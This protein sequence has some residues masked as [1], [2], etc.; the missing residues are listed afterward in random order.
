MRRSPACSPLAARL[1]LLGLTQLAPVALA[2]PKLADMLPSG[3]VLTPAELAAFEAPPPSGVTYTGEPVVAFPVLPLQVFGLHY[4]ADIVLV[5]KDPDWDMHEYARV[6]VPGRT[7][8]LAKDADPNKVQTIVA[9]TPDL[10]ALA[11]E[12]PITRYNRPMTVE[13]RSE[14]ERIDLRLA[15]VNSAGDPV[16][17]SYRGRMAKKPPS[18]RN[19]AT[20]G[21]SAN[22][23]AVV[24][25]LSRF[26]HGG[27]A[28]IEIDGHRWRLDRLLGFYAQKYLLAQTQGGVVIARFQVRPTEGGVHIQRPSP[29][30]EAWPLHSEEDWRASA[31][32]ALTTLCSSNEVSTTCYRFRDG[33]W[34]GAEVRQ[35]GRSTPVF[36]MRLDPALPDVRR[37]FEGAATSRFTFDVDGQQGHGAGVVVARWEAGEARISLIPSAPTDLARRPMEGTVRYAEGAATV[38]THR[39]PQAP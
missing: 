27:R 32:G 33:E 14:G 16:T 26:K 34:L 2:G 10:D 38:E 4:S 8:W 18:K 13:D 36:A 35:A 23:A 12:V 39:V 28:R 3:P 15:Y 21:H 9:D 11:P 7:L 17:V 5:S 37:P 1:A 30:T 22:M 20:M 6:E 25:D 29:D 19:G 24:L 31:D